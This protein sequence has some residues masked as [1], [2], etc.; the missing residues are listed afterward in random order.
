MN[1]IRNIYGADKPRLF[2]DTGDSCHAVSAALTLVHASGHV[3]C[4]AVRSETSQNINSKALCDFFIHFGHGPVDE[5]TYCIA[6]KE[7]NSVY[8]GLFLTT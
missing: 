8:V 4:E 1:I 5:L 3:T 2:F 7:S 6:R